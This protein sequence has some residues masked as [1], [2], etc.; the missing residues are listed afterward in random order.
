[1]IKPQTRRFEAQPEVFPEVRGFVENFCADARVSDHARS[2]LILVFEE[3]FVNTEKHGYPS[4]AGA[5]AGRPIW[6]TLAFTQE[7][8]EA[9]YE[10]AAPAYNPFA[11]VTTPDYSAPPEAWRVGGWGIPLIISLTRDL[12]YQRAGNRNRISFTIPIER[13]AG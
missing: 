3:L 13:P 6:L 2:V 9:V 5:A 7:G 4:T 8:I 12:R 1:M 10:D 11:K